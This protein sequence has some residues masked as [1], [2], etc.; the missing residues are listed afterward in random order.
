MEMMVDPSMVTEDIQE[1]VVNAEELQAVLDD[2]C[3]ALEDLESYCEELEKRI[4][5][6]E[7]NG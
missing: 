3:G 6:V 2:I 5:E 7:T 1:S 4:H